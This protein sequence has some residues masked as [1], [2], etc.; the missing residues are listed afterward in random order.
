M[1]SKVQAVIEAFNTRLDSPD[2]KDKL[3]EYGGV[4]IRD[5]LREQSFWR[6]I[7]TTTPW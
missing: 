7:A 6:H 1:S 5:R 4:F 3:A 2:G